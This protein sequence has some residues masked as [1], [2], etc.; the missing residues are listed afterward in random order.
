MS[1]REFSLNSLVNGSSSGLDSTASLEIVSRLTDVS[2]LGMNVIMVIHQPRYSLFSLFDDVLLLGVG[3]R[4]VYSG[5]SSQALPYF[6]GLGFQ[7]PDKENPADFFLDIISGNVS[8]PAL[9]NFEASELPVWWTEKHERLPE[10]MF[11]QTSKEEGIEM[12]I[13]TNPLQHSLLEDEAPPRI[14]LHQMAIKVREFLTGDSELEELDLWNLDLS[15][16]SSP[17][18]PAPE[19]LR[20]S[21]G[22]LDEKT[23]LSNSTAKSRALDKL[24][25]AGV[26]PW[27]I[28]ALKAI[29]V[30]FDKDNDGHLN[31]YEFASLIARFGKELSMDEMVQFKKELG[32]DRDAN[33]SFTH[34]LKRLFSLKNKQL[35]RSMQTDTEGL[36]TSLLSR[37]SPSLFFQYSCLVAREALRVMRNYPRI[38]FDIILLSIGAFLIGLFYGS[39]FSLDDILRIPLFA[40]MILGLLSTTF[41]LRWFGLDRI[42]YWREMSSGMSR[43]SYVLA[44]VTVQLWE[45][46]CHPLFFT[47]FFNGI[48]ELEAPYQLVYIL[49]VAVHWTC[50]GMGMFFSTIVAPD[51]SLLIAV[52]VP[53]IMGAFLNGISPSYK[54]SSKFVKV[55]MGTSFSRWS[56][57]AFL[58]MEYKALAPSVQIPANFW[59]NRTGYKSD[60]YWT[61]ILILFVWGVVFR[62]LTYPAL[63]FLN[64]GKQV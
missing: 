49:L 21:H 3:G 63:R 34:L 60:N 42:T 56:V 29:F 15:G 36:S 14:S 58:S 24:Q 51:K 41:G 8:L 52:L 19:Q 25:A 13:V 5:S 61:D 33:V 53:L 20:S 2:R 28:T 40:L 9:P 35:N 23:D 32:L 37:Q 4:T 26:S 62:L 47:I 17:R 1:P 30:Q 18:H 31:M 11:E 48:I 16:L 45:V 57:E 6:E 64:R 43:V 39:D 44:K 7:C 10:Y 38:F 55:I 59:F 12:K 54:T 46:F 27:H 50:S 22:D